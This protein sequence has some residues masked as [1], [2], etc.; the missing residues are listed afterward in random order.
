MGGHLL[1]FLVI[2]LPLVAADTRPERWCVCGAGVHTESVTQLID[3][4]NCVLFKAACVQIHFSPLALSGDTAGSTWMRDDD[5]DNLKKE[6][7]KSEGVTAAGG[8][9][10]SGR[11]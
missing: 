3:W 7:C 1:A 5:N 11:A 8:K 2:L 9:S 4:P 6:V 10:D